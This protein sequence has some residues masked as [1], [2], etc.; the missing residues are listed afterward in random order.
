MRINYNRKSEYVV[1]KEEKSKLEESL[2]YLMKSN[3]RLKDFDGSKISDQVRNAGKASYVERNREMID[4]SDYCI[5]F[6]IED[7]TPK[8]NPQYGTSRKSGTK[9]AYEYAVRRKKMI[10]NI[11]DLM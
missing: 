9:L 4:D 7:Y 11:A 5:F 6:Y 3:I 2:N 8:S 10:I 1:K